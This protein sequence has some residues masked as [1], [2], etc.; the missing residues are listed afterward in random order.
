MFSRE[1]VDLISIY[2][3]VSIDPSWRNL[4]HIVLG[5]SIHK[6]LGYMHKLRLT[7]ISDPNVDFVSNPK[8]LWKAIL[9]DRL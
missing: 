2:S 8:Y 3:H 9:D 7:C 6:M 5:K 1:I 4:P